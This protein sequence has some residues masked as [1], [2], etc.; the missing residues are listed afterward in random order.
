MGDWNT[1]I[2]RLGDMIPEGIELLP[3]GSRAGDDHRR[4]AVEYLNEMNATGF[5]TDD[6]RARRAEHALSARTRAELSVLTSDL[7]PRPLTRMETFRA[8]KRSPQHVRIVLCWLAIAVFAILG[9]LIP[10]FLC[11][12]PHDSI[13]AGG[14][15]T[16]VTVGILTAAF[17]MLCGIW[18]YKTWDD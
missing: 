9:E 3:S 12:T 18:T 5:I 11:T 15:V 8:R 7:P 1:D 14:T 10:A 4:Q 13:S 17:G 2:A 6:E 16:M